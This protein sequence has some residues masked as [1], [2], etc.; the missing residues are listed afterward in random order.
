[1]QSDGAAGIFAFGLCARNLNRMDESVSTL[2]LC[3]DVFRSSGG[4]TQSRSQTSD[5]GVKTLIELY[6][7][8]TR[9]KPRPE[10]F[11]GDGGP[12]VSSRAASTLID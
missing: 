6:I 4:I 1:M 2:G 7:C 10:F 5:G 12:G 8:A 11:T 3:L 9:P